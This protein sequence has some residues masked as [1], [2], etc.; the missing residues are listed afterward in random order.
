[1]IE[2]NNFE[3]SEFGKPKTSCLYAVWCRNWPLFKGEPHLL[4]VGSTR[5]LYSR[6]SNT[7]HPYLFTFNKLF[8]KMV[9][10]SFHECHTGLK[11]NE[12]YLINKHQPILNKQWR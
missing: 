6:I 8:D 3:I 9:W 7:K 2:L 4:Y 1:M 12:R 10:V 5:N 11:E